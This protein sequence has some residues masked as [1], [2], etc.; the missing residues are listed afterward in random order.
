MKHRKT[1]SEAIQA[2]RKQYRSIG[3]NYYLVI[4]KWLALFVMLYFVLR[5]I[6][7]NF[8]ITVFSQVSIL[9]LVSYLGLNFLSKLFYAFRWYLIS[10]QG[11]GLQG[12]SSLSLFRI[13]LIGEFV[14]ISMPTSLGGEVVRIMKL[15][16]LTEMGAKST[17]SVLIDRIAGLV[18]MLLIVFILFPVWGATVVM[19]QPS[20]FAI[21]MVFAVV[22]LVLGIILLYWQGKIKLIF[23]EIKQ[24]N[25]GFPLLITSILLSALGHLFFASGYYLLFREFEP[26]SFWVATGVTLTV[27]LARS[28]PISLLGIGISDGSM[29]ALASL[30]GMA[31]SAEALSVVIIAL[32][33]RYIFALLGLLFELSVDGKVALK[34]LLK[35]KDL[36]GEL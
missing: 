30:A 13:N 8:D 6:N 10:S 2:L 3:N 25:F 34:A 31:T 32:S 33:F 17:T 22:I 4:L 28:I 15:T 29:V 24:L 1:M 18:G 21:I 9:T 12:F 16:T 26:L 35:H 27:Q 23:R 7:L 36:G 14:S 19:W 20:S 5:F 11:L